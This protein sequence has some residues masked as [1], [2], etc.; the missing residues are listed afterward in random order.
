DGKPKH[1]PWEDWRP[2]EDQH[3]SDWMRA[4]APAGDA[5]FVG[6]VSWAGELG[7]GVRD[8]E[9]EQSTADTQTTGDAKGASVAAPRG[10]E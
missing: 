9:A 7:Y 2:G 1:M 8:A 6:V 4:T 5:Y 10:H 3:T